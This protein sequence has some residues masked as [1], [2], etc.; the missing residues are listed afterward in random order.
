MAKA[1]AEKPDVV[2]VFTDHSLYYGPL[3]RLETGY[4]ILTPEKAAEWMKV[5]GSVRIATPTEVAAA[6]GV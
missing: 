1:K 5:S 3:G 2:A 6:Y 4:T